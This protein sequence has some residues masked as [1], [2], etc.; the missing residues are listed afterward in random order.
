MR[1]LLLL[2]ALAPAA[3][4]A[5]DS[6]PTRVL[7]EGKRPADR[8][9]TTVRT[10]NDKDFFLRPPATL[11]AWDARRP[12]VREQV[13]VATGL[14]P[15]PPKQPLKPVIHGRIDRDGYSVEKVFFA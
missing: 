1:R 10:L 12:L 5:A 6:D 14:W 7:P 13:L 15:L 2:L 4:L 8:R 9:L 11:A 3:S